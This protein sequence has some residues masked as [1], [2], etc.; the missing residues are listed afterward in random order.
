MGRAFCEGINQMEL[1]QISLGGADT[2]VAGQTLAGLPGF[3]RIRSQLNLTPT[4]EDRKYN[5]S[6]FIPPRIWQVWAR[7]WR[8]VKTGPR[9]KG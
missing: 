6:L 1:A 8:G 3:L 4:Y 9:W 5:R 7:L 2:T